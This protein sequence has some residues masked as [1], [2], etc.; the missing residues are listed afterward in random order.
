MHSTSSRLLLC[1]AVFLLSACSKEQVQRTVHEGENQTINK[2]AESNKAVSATRIS[3][4]SHDRRLQLLEKVKQKKAG[5]KEEVLQLAD[6]VLEIDFALRAA[7]ENKEAGQEFLHI[8]NTGLLH[9]IREKYPQTSKLLERYYKAASFGCNSVLQDC[10]T[11][12]FFSSDPLTYQVLMAHAK[13]LSSSGLTGNK[14]ANYYSTLQLALEMKRGRDRELDLMYLAH[15]NDY[16]H[17][18]EK[19]RGSERAKHIKI[20][21]LI[22]TDFE[23]DPPKRNTA[24]MRKFLEGLKPWRFSRHEHHVLS[25]DAEKILSLASRFLLSDEASINAVFSKELQEIKRRQEPGSYYTAMEFLKS[26]ENA[27]LYNGMGVQKMELAES[28]LLYIIDRLYTGS[29]D[30][31]GASAIW[32]NLSEKLGPSAGLNLLGVAE[33]YAKIQILYMSAYSS[34]FLRQHYIEKEQSRKDRLQYVLNRSQSLDADWDAAIGKIQKIKTFL[35][36]QFLSGDETVYEAYKKTARR[37]DIIRE[38]IKI[39]AA[40]PNTILFNQ[41]VHGVEGNVNSYSG[42]RLSIDK[43]FLT[44]VFLGNQEPWFLFGTDGAKLTGLQNIYSIFFAFQ[45]GVFETSSQDADPTEETATDA[46]MS[47]QAS[48]EAGSLV[49][50]AKNDDLFRFMSFFINQMTAQDLAKLIKENDKLSDQVNSGEYKELVQMCSELSEGGSVKTSIHFADLAKYIVVGDARGGIASPLLKT[51]VL[52]MASDSL[53]GE[54]LL[55][56]LSEK[57]TILLSRLRN[58][59]IVKDLFAQGLEK[60][61]K[62]GIMGEDKRQELLS[63]VDAVIEEKMIPLR[64]SLK[65]YYSYVT[66]IYRDTSCLFDLFNKEF[67]MQTLLFSE[68]EQYFMTVYLEMAKMRGQ[69]STASAELRALG[70]RDSSSTEISEDLKDKTGYEGYQGTISR[71]HYSMNKVDILLKVTE[72]LSEIKPDQQQDHLFPVEVEVTMPPLFSNIDLIK[73]PKTT[74]IQTV[75]WNP[76]AKSFIDSA[77]EKLNSIQEKEQLYINWMANSSD[78]KFAIVRNKVALQLYLSE[79]V[80]RMLGTCSETTQEETGAT[81]IL[82]TDMYHLPAE[83]ILSDVLR[84]V[85]YLQMSEDEIAMIRRTNRRSKFDYAQIKELFFKKGQVEPLTYF[86]KTFNL[87]SEEILPK[88]ELS[89][90]GLRG[91]LRF[92]RSQ[93]DLDEFLFPVEDQTKEDIRS[94]YMP[95]ISSLLQKLAEFLTAVDSFSGSEIPSLLFDIDRAPMESM[96]YQEQTQELLNSTTRDDFVRFLRRKT[97]QETNCFFSASESD[98]SDTNLKQ[99]EEILGTRAVGCGG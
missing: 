78:L 90:L 39:L 74:D 1:L 14:L 44:R 11:V 2:N 60:Q 40:V 48:E 43:N 8:L 20:V 15:A 4:M 51:L 32:R 66:T 26:Q 36:E 76:S 33:N 92:Y 10:L 34:Q 75:A 57:R 96:N 21:G 50:E 99:V 56:S 84:L 87:L 13:Q 45:M 12:R 81:N 9:F 54:N 29:I 61:V 59:Q 93:R 73:K 47:V 71:D 79:P 65:T 16:T 95:E 52:D 94:R 88:L 23:Q 31:A 55:A 82:C 7:S 30:N 58:I 91:P 97:Y 18:L 5:Y 27:T 42:K 46:A 77:L 35:D 63:K 19:D 24:E 49:A 25:E 80:T 6:Q 64:D 28:P 41:L 37:F 83:E 68:L 3:A 89:R 69:E 38:N 67:Q 85:D 98:P 53:N 86:E 62:S 22:L 70:F 17:F 72:F